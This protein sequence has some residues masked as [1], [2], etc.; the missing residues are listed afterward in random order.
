MDVIILQECIMSLEAIWKFDKQEISN[1]IDL[2]EEVYKTCDII[3]VLE[4]MEQI[5]YLKEKK[6]TKYLH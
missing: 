6:T 5:A 2:S 1:Q 4:Q 3:Y